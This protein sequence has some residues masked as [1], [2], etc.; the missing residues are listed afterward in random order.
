MKRFL[1]GILAL[2][3]AMLL[4]AAA[5]LFLPPA[6]QL[7]LRTANRFLPVTVEVAEYRHVPGRLSL[8]GV[9]VATPRGTLCEM[10]GLRI[11]YRPLALFLGRVEVSMLELENPRITIRVD[12]RPRLSVPPL[13]ID[14]LG[15]PRSTT[16]LSD[17]G[18]IEAP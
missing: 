13:S 16:A 12:T 5:V 15:T 2:I 4:L 11:E 17:I 7:G 14:Q 1:F 10:A 18:A 6:F 3:A 8:S 9:H